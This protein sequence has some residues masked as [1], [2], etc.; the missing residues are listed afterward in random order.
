MR[1]Y[2]LA[3]LYALAAGAILGASGPLLLS[4]DG[5]IG[6]TAHLILSA[7]WAWAALAFFMGMLRPSKLE[8]A[9]MGALSLVSASLVY[10]VVKASQGEF[11]GVDLTDHTGQTTYFD[12]AGFL[13]KVIL[14]WVFACLLGPIVGLAGNLTRNGPFRLL[15]QTVIPLVAIGEMTMR[16]GAEAS[17][18]DSLVTTIWSTTRIVAV[19]ALLGLVL[20]S[21]FDRW[22][23]GSARQTQT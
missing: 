1:S 10:Y 20:F 22:G 21:I 17:S 11:Q 13:T 16:L 23:R 4:S 15:G 8:A 14:W 6:R 2:F 5:T 9:A 12:W 19:A 3:G 7:G 18:Q